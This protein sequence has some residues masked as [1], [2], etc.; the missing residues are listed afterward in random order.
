[1]PIV[2]DL[3]NDGTASFHFI[4]GTIEVAIPSD[5]EEFHGPASH[6]RFIESVSQNVSDEEACMV[7]FDNET[8]SSTPEHK[9]RDMIK[10]LQPKSSDR[11][12]S[13]MDQLNEV[14]RTDGP[15]D[16]IIGYSEGGT[17]AATFIVDHFRQ[18]AIM[19]IQ[20]QLRCAVFIS[21]GPPYNSDGTEL[22]LADECGQIITIPTCHIM[23]S[24]D[25]QISGVLALYHLCN[26]KLA[27]LVDHGRAHRLP[28]DP[29][30]YQLMIKGIRNLIART[31]R[32]QV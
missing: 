15:F 32:A 13:V 8:D 16:G 12:Q 19:K 17:V 1:M 18:C 20:P 28:N 2:N 29:R 24:N 21:G 5:Q 9:Y 10:A 6:R 30:L 27:T 25:R 3:E 31:E 11:I 26:E 23:G 7:Y 4:H 14:M 22:Y